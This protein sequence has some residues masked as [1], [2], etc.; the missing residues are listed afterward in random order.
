M[1]DKADCHGVSGR[2]RVILGPTDYHYHLYI[3]LLG[4]HVINLALFVTHTSSDPHVF[5]AA[6]VGIGSPVLLL[7]GLTER[8]GLHALIVREVLRL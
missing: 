6:D 4:Q 7:D 3:R 5:T 1:R 8:T 2:K